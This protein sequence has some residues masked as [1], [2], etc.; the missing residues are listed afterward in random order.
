MKDPSYF[1]SKDNNLWSTI[2]SNID[3]VFLLFIL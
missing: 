2:N 1:D 3:E